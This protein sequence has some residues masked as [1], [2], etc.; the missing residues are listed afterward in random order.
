MA[1]KVAPAFFLTSLNDLEKL[2]LQSIDAE[3]AFTS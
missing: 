1:F 3:R 2:I